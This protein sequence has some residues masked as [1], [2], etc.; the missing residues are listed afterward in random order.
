VTAA[1]RKADVARARADAKKYK[2]NSTFANTKV[3]PSFKM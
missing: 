3:D 1:N 2:L